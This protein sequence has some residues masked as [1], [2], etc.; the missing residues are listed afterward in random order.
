MY[1]F[2][3]SSYTKPLNQDPQLETIIKPLS[4]VLNLKAKTQFLEYKEAIEGAYY[5]YQG[6]TKHYIYGEDGSEKILYTLTKGWVFGETPLFLREPTGLISE[7]MED[8]ILWKIPFTAFQRLFDTNKLFRDAIMNCMA[9]KMWIMRHEI[10][11]L[12]FNPCKR[13]ILHLICCTVDSKSLQ[14][15]GWY[16][17]LTHYTQYE[18]STIVGSA[19]VTTSKLINEL[20]N[21]GHIRI[22]NRRIQVSK[23]IYEEFLTLDELM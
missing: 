22:L 11:N 7:T 21:E 8:S 18:I 15:D 19:R 12:V 13:R 5:V 14:P 23:S 10:E 3:N 17:L 6:R 2:F 9:R 16:N 4:I 20:C 1:H